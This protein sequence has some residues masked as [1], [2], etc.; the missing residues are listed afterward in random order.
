MMGIPRTIPY[1][2][3]CSLYPE[4]LHWLHW[5]VL[6]LMQLS[7]AAIGTVVWWQRRV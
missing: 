4:A 3:T 5:I 2:V 6:I 7:P 1:A